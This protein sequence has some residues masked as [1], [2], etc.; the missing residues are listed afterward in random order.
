MKYIVSLLTLGVLCASGV[1]SASA[2][3]LSPVLIDFNF[4]NSATCGV[5]GSSCKLVGASGTYT[6]GTPTNQVFT[7]WSQSGF[8]LTPVAPTKVYFNANQGST[9]PS[10]SNAAKPGLNFG[11]GTGGNSTSPATLGVTYTLGSGDFIFDSV[12]L[13]GGDYTI[14]GYTGAGGSTLLFTLG[15]ATTPVSNPESTTTYTQISCGAYCND[16]ITKLTITLQNGGTPAT[17]LERLDNLDLTP[18]PE[19]SSL[20]LLGT[21]LL[22]ACGI[23]YR[24]RLRATV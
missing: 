23:V 5:A 3:P 8:S 6:S 12:Y 16:E 2:S 9:L 18:T 24:K 15:S 17:T 22:G 11:T 19:P 21:G 10:T 14:K 1:P 20:M 7:S 4:N 13:Q